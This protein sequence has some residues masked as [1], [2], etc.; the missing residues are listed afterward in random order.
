[1]N[2]WRLVRQNHINFIRKS[3]SRSISMNLPISNEPLDCCVSLMISFKTA[4]HVSRSMF[5]KLR[6]FSGL[7]TRY[8]ALH[9]LSTRWDGYVKRKVGAWLLVFTIELSL[10]YNIPVNAA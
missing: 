9:L 8:Q 4:G 1:M 3:A 7:T 5:T 10:F 6:L 2:L